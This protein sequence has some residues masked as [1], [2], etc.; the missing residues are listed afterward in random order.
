MADLVIDRAQPADVAGITTILNEAI[1]YTSA[2]WYDEPRTEA[3][4]STWIEDRT[5]AGQ[6]FLVARLDG[7]VV[8][9]TSYGQFRPWPGYRHSVELSIFVDGGHRRQ[10]IGRRLVEALLDEARRSKLHAIIAGVEA[11]NEASLELHRQLGFVEVGRMPEV[12]RK[13]DRWLTLVLMQ[14]ML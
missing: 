14:R 6:P 4:V 1:T 3:D 12:G 9:F 5:R 7:Q 10:G 2:V 13:F 11:A 8:G